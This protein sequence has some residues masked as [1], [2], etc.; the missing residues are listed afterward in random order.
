M[1][2]LRISGPPGSSAPLTRKGYVVKLPSN[3]FAV[4]PGGASAPPS[5]FMTASGSTRWLSGRLRR[6]HLRASKSERVCALWP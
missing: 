3:D 6:A 2:C 5:A 1:S 4:V